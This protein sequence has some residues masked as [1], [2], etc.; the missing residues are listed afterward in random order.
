MLARFAPYYSR[1]SDAPADRWDGDV[2]VFHPRLLTGPGQT[3][4]ALEAASYARAVLP[5]VHRMQRQFS[6]D[7]IHAH[8]TYPDGVVASLLG[9]LYGVPVVI[10]EHSLWLPWMR[11]HSLVRR[12]AVWA[13]RRCSSHIAVSRAVRDHIGEVVGD[14]SKVTVIPNLVDGCVFKPAAD[15]R[16]VSGQILFVGIVRQ[17]KGLDVL[18]QALRELRRVQPTIRLKVVGDP[19]Y[20]S[21]RQEADRLGDLAKELG[22]ADCVELVG[23]KSPAETAQ[24]MAESQVVVLPSRR[25]SFGTVLIEALACGTPVVAT[26]SGGPEDVVT[27]SVGKLV[28]PDDSAALARALADVLGEPNAYSSDALRRYALDRFGEPVVAQQIGNLYASLLGPA[29]RLELHERLSLA[30]QAG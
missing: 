23:K 15:Q 6:F 26:R 5:A 12:Q 25:E 4:Y 10:T 9:S 11:D 3:M 29:G 28:P 22:V 30:T 21:Y 2:Q 27:P 8:F 14:A 7:V 24:L 1:Y 20:R 16:R 19:F 18:F 13:A 17:A